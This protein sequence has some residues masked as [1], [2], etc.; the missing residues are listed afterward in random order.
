MLYLELEKRF[1]ERA[2]VQKVLEEEEQK[3]KEQEFIIKQQMKVCIIVKEFLGRIRVTT[4]RDHM[5]L[6]I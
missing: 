6:N 5:V 3:R 2:K 1:D 4:K